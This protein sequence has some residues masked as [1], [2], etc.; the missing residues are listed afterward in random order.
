MID[1][2]EIKL[3]DISTEQAILG[4]LLLEGN[5]LFES[6]IGILDKNDFYKKSHQTIFGT[7][8]KSFEKNKGIDLVTI[9]ERLN[10]ADSLEKIGGVTYLTQLA[11]SVPTTTNLPHYVK[12][13]KDYSYKRAILFKINTFKDKGINAQ[14]LV[15]DIV[16]IPKY[17]E[18]KEKTNKDIILETMDDAQRGMDFRFPD[19]F[20]KIND[21]MGGLDRGDLAIIGGYPS[22]GKSSLMAELVIGYANMDFKV[23]VCTLEMSAKA[24]MRRILANMNKINTMKFRKNLLTDLDKEKIKAVIPIVDKAWNYNCVRVYTIED[25]IRVTNKYNPDILFIDYLQ[26]ISEPNQRLNRYEQATRHTLQIQK[27]TKEKNILTFLLSQFNRPLEGKIHRPHNNNLR[28]SGAIEERADAIF[29]IY[30]ERKL[31]MENLYRQDG[32]DP[33]YVEVN[34]TKSKD[35]ATGGLNYNYYPEYH[36]WVDP[37]DDDKEPI[38]YKKAKEVSGE[39][40]KRNQE[41]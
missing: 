40:Y 34:I 26:N 29:L 39:Y 18:I 15:E 12:I 24:N 38:I 14:K 36:R 27:L 23:L 28:D 32:D 30:W 20:G 10:E 16:N 21:I 31:R 11:N 41:N 8:S 1:N 37:D 35:G 6:V 9:T 4:S 33:E 19:N 13:I 2:P 22:N 25:I 7:I 5:K 3:Y 17:E